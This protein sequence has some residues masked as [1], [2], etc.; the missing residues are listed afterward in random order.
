MVPRLEVS[1]I[2]GANPPTQD[3]VRLWAEQGI[4]VR[5]RPEWVFVKL[6]THGCVPENAR[7]LLG[8]KMRQ[9]HAVLQREFN[10]GVK[11]QLH[12]VTA[13]EMYNIAKAAEAGMQGA[14]GQWRDWLVDRPPVCQGRGGGGK[15]N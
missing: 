14:P 8:E 2:C 3:R 13:R 15:S 10:D 6:H 1:D 7:V 12:Y 11:W 9:M 4:G 5:G